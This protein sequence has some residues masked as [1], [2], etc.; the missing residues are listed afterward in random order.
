MLFS[1]PIVTSLMLILVSTAQL[2]VANGDCESDSL[3]L[4][5]DADF[6]DLTS[7]LVTVTLECFSDVLEGKEC[8]PDYSEAQKVCEDDLDGD[9]FY[10]S[11]TFDCGDQGKIRQDNIPSCLP[12]SCTKDEGLLKEVLNDGT[13]NYY[14]GCTFEGFVFEDLSAAFTPGA[15]AG[16]LLAA[17][18]VAAL[19][20][21]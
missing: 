17:S 16:S 10:Y 9:W 5:A 1:R 2:K 15:I 6:V 18:T 12:S 14:Q 21:M 11:A 3:S 8:T 4:A 20:F 13:D 7:E 19:S